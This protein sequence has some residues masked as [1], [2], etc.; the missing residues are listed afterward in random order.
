MYAP[1]IIYNISL[2]NIKPLLIK[3]KGYQS[4]FFL[5]YGA[6]DI[7]VKVWHSQDYFSLLR[8]DYVS[9][10]KNSCYYL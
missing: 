3:V 8:S 6:T 10:Q 9:I 5:F 4:P 1:Y 7:I 2:S